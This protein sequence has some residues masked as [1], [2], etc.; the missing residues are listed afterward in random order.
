MTDEC[1]FQL[2]RKNGLT[3]SL[4]KDFRRRKSHKITKKLTKQILNLLNFKTKDIYQVN[5]LNTLCSGSMKIAYNIKA[6][7]TKY[8]ELNV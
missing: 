4:D 8:M 5:V 7:L 1:K 2:Q 6:G 3:G